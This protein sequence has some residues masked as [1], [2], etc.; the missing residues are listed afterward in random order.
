MCIRDSHR[1]GGRVFYLHRE[2]ETLLR[3]RVGDG[4]GKSVGVDAFWKVLLCDAQSDK[5]FS[6]LF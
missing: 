5:L 2:G 3:Q 1:G 4:K 6:L